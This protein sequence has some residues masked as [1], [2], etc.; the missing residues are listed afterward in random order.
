MLPHLTFPSSVKLHLRVE[1]TNTDKHDD[2]QKAFLDDE[3]AKK[4]WG[5][6]KDYIDN[7]NEPVLLS[8]LGARLRSEFGETIAKS[9]WFGGGSISRFVH[10]RG[11]E[12]GIL[13]YEHYVW[14]ANKHDDPQKAFL[15][16]EE[17]KKCKDVVKDNIDNS[18]APVLHANLDT[19]LRSEF[20]ETVDKK[21]RFDE[22]SFSGPLG[23]EDDIRLGSNHILDVN[24]HAEPETVG[25]PAKTR[26]IPAFI[27]QFCQLVDFP[28]L[29]SKEWEVAIKKFVEYT[30]KHDEFNFSESAKWIRTSLAEDGFQVGQNALN[31]MIRATMYNGKLSNPDHQLSADDIRESLIKKVTDHH[32]IAFL[33]LSDDNIA[34][35]DAWLSGKETP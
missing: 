20:G 18:N 27:Q 7:S 5:V 31:Y 22:G 23:S 30:D 29:T 15:D 19:R 13:M 16:D 11:D 8:E 6:A 10:F 25:I 2:P 35:L 1:F 33:D 24:K 3:E 4:C 9:N 34:S 14:N 12:D 28:R 17:A 32:Q 26:D 21:K